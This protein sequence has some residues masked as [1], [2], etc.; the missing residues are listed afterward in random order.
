VFALLVVVV[1]LGAMAA[2]PVERYADAANR[3]DALVRERDALAQEVDALEQRAGEL[4]EPEEIELLARS[5]LGLVLPGEEAY[6]IVGPSP[7][8]SPQPPAAEDGDVP[9]YRR[10][11]RLAS[12]LLR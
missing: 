3:V 1:L 2:G 11:G 12:G 8:P 7:S 5:E 4:H 6:V 10:L 9:W